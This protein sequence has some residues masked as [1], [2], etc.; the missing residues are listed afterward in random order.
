[1][2][3]LS[4][5]MRVLFG[6]MLLAGVVISIMVGIQASSH[7][8]SFDSAMGSAAF[9]LVVFVIVISVLMLMTGRLWGTRRR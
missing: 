6:L 5:I 2:T 8:A 3:V 9:T 7:G 1:M 4:I